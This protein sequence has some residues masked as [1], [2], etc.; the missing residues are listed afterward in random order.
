[1]KIPD[2]FTRHSKLTTDHSQLTKQLAEQDQAIKTL[3]NELAGANHRCA[4]A[5]EENAA[6]R[7]IVSEEAPIA[8]LDLATTWKVERQALKEEIVDL[9][10][11]VELALDALDQVRPD[12]IIAFCIR[13]KMK[14]KIPEMKSKNNNQE[15]TNAR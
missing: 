13:E 9:E 14:G 6:L 12:S 11:M 3:R 7:K 15:V 2:I 8:A 10:E 1:M 4:A 5:E